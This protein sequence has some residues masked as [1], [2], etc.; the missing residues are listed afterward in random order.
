M[1]RM[2]LILL[3][4][5]CIFSSGCIS[6]SDEDNVKDVVR[7]YYSAYNNRDSDTVIDLFSQELLEKNG[8]KDTIKAN[9]E[10]LFTMA[11]DTELELKIL[12]FLNIRFLNETVFINFDVRLTDVDRNEEFNLTFK[13]VKEEGMWKILEM[14]E[15]S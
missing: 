10:D 2:L 7:E 14:I 6:S 1:K 9:L 8:G 12:R 15:E 13:L 5:A 4:F 11:D 3:M